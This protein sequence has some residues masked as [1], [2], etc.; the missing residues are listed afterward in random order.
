MRVPQRQG[1]RGSLKWTQLLLQTPAGPLD[2]AVREALSLAPDVVIDW[3]SPRNDD[4]YAEYRDTS[5]LREIGLEHLEANLREFWPSRGPQWDAL[6]RTS[7]GRV[8]LIEA[9]AHAGELA[10]SCAART[11]SRLLI[12]RALD[13]AKKHYGA[14]PRADWANGYY[15]YANRL[16]HLHFLRENG[17]AAELMFV[18]FVND[19]DVG[20]PSSKFE[21]AAVVKKCHEALGLPDDRP[22]PGSHTVFIDVSKL[23]T[24]P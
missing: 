6:G 14:E 13:A 12:D 8:I 5:F 20:G 2:A 10:S 15:Q 18:Y 9:K 7:D 11:T 19:R 16:A 4:E 1:S 21:W 24:K 17:V 22:I 3:K 23:A